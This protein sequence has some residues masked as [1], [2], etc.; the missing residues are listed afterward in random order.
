LLAV[1]TPG[2][3]LEITAA[4]AEEN[5][6]GVGEDLLIAELSALV[7]E[8]K[9]DQLAKRGKTSVPE[10]KEK[11]LRYVEL[12]DDGDRAKMRGICAAHRMPVVKRKVDAAE[13]AAVLPDV[14]AYC[15]KA[16][17]VSAGRDRLPDLYINLALQEQGQSEFRSAEQAA[18]LKNDEAGRTTGLILRAANAAQGDYASITGK[19]KPLPCPLAFDAGFTWGYRS[20]DKQQPYELTAADAERIAR[21]CYDPTVKEISLKDALVPAQKAGL[22]AGAWLG[23]KQRLEVGTRQ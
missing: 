20:P 4:K 8:L 11:Y 16:I 18:L 6:K 21:A 12:V 19:T 17:E 14:H 10:L 1:F 22:F 15:L 5:G 7:A 23:R 13:P 3:R 2:A 9:Y